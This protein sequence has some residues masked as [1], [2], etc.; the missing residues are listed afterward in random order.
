M[1]RLAA[2]AL[3][4]SL[5][6]SVA[7]AEP[8]AYEFD[9]SHANLS[10]TYDHLGY[11]TTDGRF[12][13]WDGTLMIDKETPENSSIEFTINID[14]LDTF[15]ADRDTHLKSPDFFDAAKFPQAT[16]KSTS[17]EQT[18][19]NQLAVTGDL[20]IKGITKPT[21]LTVDVVGLGEHPMAKKEAAG[22][23]VNTV[24]K[25]SDF[26]MDMFVPYVGDEVTVTFHAET[27]IADTTN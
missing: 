10:F 23:A 17:I 3:S 14:S 25:R 22:F 27:L 12:G 15:W 8:V 20:T 4:L 26:G 16:F 9:K 21:T 19:E 11:S 2:S 18:G 1:F 24:I 5:L 6:T 13:D 7:L